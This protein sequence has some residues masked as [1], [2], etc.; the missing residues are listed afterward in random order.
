MLIGLNGQKGAGKDTV[1]Q[2]AIHIVS[3]SPKIS[4]MYVERRAF[5]DKLKQSFAALFDMTFE[6]VEALKN[7][8][9][10]DVYDE[11]GENIKRLSFRV[12]LQRYGTE[13][14]RNVFG[15]SF[16]IDSALPLDFDHRKGVVFVTDVRF[17]NE[18]ERI[19]SMN[20]I[21]WLIKGANDTPNPAHISE[22]P[23][24]DNLIDGVIDNTV[25]DDNFASLDAQIRTA[26]DPSARW[27]F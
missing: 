4:D 5:A 3:T 26:I 23:L 19:R 2:R 24:P 10:V 17:P 11:T 16:W 21:V 18:A 9:E 22:A 8:G 14:H 13:A 20:G 6:E 25:L 7:F 12:L 1:F 15:D 27:T